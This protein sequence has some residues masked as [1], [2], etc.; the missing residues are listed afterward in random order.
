M[1]WKRKVRHARE[2]NTHPS[3]YDVKLI[4][5]SPQLQKLERHVQTIMINNYDNQVL[6][7]E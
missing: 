2:S 7:L 6:F 3:N 4:Y 1:S 5:T